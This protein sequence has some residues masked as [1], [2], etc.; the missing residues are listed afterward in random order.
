MTAGDVARAG[1]TVRAATRD[2]LPRLWE[3]M[4]GLAEYER[5][6]EFVSGTREQLGELL[7]GGRDSLEA[8]V[9]E[10]GGAVVGYAIVYLRYSSFRT[11]RRL[12]LEDLF[13]EPAARGTGA[14][15][16]LLADVARF[17]VE[18]GCDRVDWDVLD[19]NQ[20]AIDFYERLGGAAV[21]KEWTQFALGGDALR[22]LADS[23][24][25]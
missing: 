19:W 13:V 17:A 4:H 5:M 23:A 7:F 12:W 9:A 2:D 16:A 6:T 18:R 3:L 8:R 21:A 10:S 15:R 22:A 25:R 14:G 11:T 1:A 24:K 20:P